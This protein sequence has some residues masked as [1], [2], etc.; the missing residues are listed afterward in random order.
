M[1]HTLVVQLSGPNFLA[2]AQ[3]IAHHLRPGT[4]GELRVRLG[5]ISPESPNVKSAMVFMAKYLKPG[6]VVHFIV[7]AAR[8]PV[9]KPPT[10]V[11][12]PAAPIAL[13]APLALGVSLA[14]IFLTT[15][16]SF[17]MQTNDMQQA[18]TISTQIA[19]DAQKQ[20][21]ERWKILQDTQTRI[22]EI[23]QDVTVN[24]AQTQSR[25]YKAFDAYIRG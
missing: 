6:A 12:G 7:P 17:D 14:Q 8:T 21:M 11:G 16:E 2:R 4:V 23:Q 22:F 24:K 3:E 25:S 15:A 13:P 10:T 1:A 5:S 9:P 20:Q 18:Q 19:A